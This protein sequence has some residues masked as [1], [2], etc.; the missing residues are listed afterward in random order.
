VAHPH[1]TLLDDR[2]RDYLQEQTLRILEMVRARFESAKA[3]ALLADAGC[4]V[5]EAA[6]VVRISRELVARTIALF[7]HTVL[8]AARDPQKDALLEGS[9]TFLT[10]AGICPMW[11]IGRPAR[12]AS[13]P[14]QTSSRDLRR[15][16]MRSSPLMSHCRCPTGRPRQSTSCW[17]RSERTPDPHADGCWR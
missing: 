10:T 12:T 16:S 17:L 13:R 11:S 8:L 6:E 7:E 1:L 5:D 4:P 9:H 15:W 3:R 14:C 2:D